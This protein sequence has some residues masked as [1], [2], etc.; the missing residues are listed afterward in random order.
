MKLN[1]AKQIQETVEDHL[2]KERQEEEMKVLIRR[3]IFRILERVKGSKLT[4]E[5]KKQIE[6]IYTM[7]TLEGILGEI[8]NVKD[9]S[10]IR[11]TI[12]KYEWFE[13]MKQL[14]EE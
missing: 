13:T 10:K 1:S 9:I 12:Y 8:W 5:F 6:G 2:W 7:E 4:Y 11:G 14:D 3:S